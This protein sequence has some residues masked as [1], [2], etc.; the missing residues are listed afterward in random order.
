MTD[1]HVLSAAHDGTHEPSGE[2]SVTH[3]NAFKGQAGHN[4]R[5]D[6]ETVHAFNVSIS[7]KNSSP[8]SQLQRWVKYCN[9][10]YRMHIFNSHAFLHWIKYSLEPL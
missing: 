5:A 3:S 1:A 2:W 6:F 4:E 7:K 8:K 10:W 9:Q